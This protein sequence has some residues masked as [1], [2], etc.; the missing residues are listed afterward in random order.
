MV[1]FRNL[2]NTFLTYAMLNLGCNYWNITPLQ[3]EKYIYCKVCQSL[4]YLQVPVI[5]IEIF[6]L[7]H[8]S[9]YIIIIFKSLY[10]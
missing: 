8:K 7:I 5:K 10:Y 1:M 4:Y 2:L 3:V 6:Y 9:I